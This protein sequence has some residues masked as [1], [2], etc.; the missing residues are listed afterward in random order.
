MVSLPMS[1]AGFSLLSTKHTLT[2][3]GFRLLFL[4]TTVL[5]L[6]GMPRTSI[7]TTGP[8]NKDQELHPQGTAAV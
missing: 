6:R 1:K 2:G 7:S 5:A 3:L 4:V 8:D